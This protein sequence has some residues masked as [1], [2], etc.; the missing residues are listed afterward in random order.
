[1]NYDAIIIGTGQAGPSLAASLAKNGSRVAIVEKSYLGGTCV[2]VG[3]TPTKAYVASARRAFIAKNSSDL[4]IEIKGDVHINLKAIKERK[5]KIVS[6]SRNGLESVFSN[7][8]NIDLIRGK[9]KFLSNT[10][11]EV[12]GK[13]YEADRFYIN[14]G[15]RPR[16]PKGFENVDFLTNE[17]ILELETIPEHLIIVGGGYIGLEFGQMFSRFGS[18]VSIL[19]RGD[20]L[21][22]HEDPE[23]GKAIQEIFENEGIE[24]LLNS[25]CITA[26]KNGETLEVTIQSEQQ[27]NKI[28]GSHLL[29]AA[30]RLPNTTDLGLENTDVSLDDRDFIEV[31]DALKTKAS[32]I[33][34]LGDCNGKGAFTHTAYNDFQIVNS[35]LFG[36]KERKLS[37]RFTCYAAFID[38]PLARVGMNLQDI[39][40]AG[41]KAK[42]ASR[43]M[44]KIARAKEMGETQGMLK[45]YIE[46]DSEKILGA[47][48]LGTG[49]DE[50]IHT[51]IDQM[52]AKQPFT[53]IR[54]AVHIHPTVSEL[55]PTMLEN[56][57]PLEEE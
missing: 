2:N 50:Y 41:I 55:L 18:K 7:N 15:A 47:T 49:A 37:D 25:E 17:S 24:V 12:N 52:Y 51:I 6:D 19:D 29:L 13:T 32:N 28:R 36:D 30:G 10:S 26:E 4:G 34:A 31:N 56:L 40:K 38:P 22:K 48:F 21:L 46:E 39:K 9:A 53:V 35:H 11:V 1:M 16:I 3:C 57:K 54:D 42:V 8:K 20:Q 45:I 27:K 5:D 14:V 23:F 43:P 33:W 44:S